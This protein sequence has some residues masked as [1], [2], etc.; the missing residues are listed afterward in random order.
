MLIPSTDHDRHESFGNVLQILLPVVVMVVV[1]EKGV[2]ARVVLVGSHEMLSLTED[3]AD[4]SIDARRLYTYL[5]LE[6]KVWMIMYYKKK[7][8]REKGHGS[9]AEI[10]R[11]KRVKEESVKDLGML[12]IVCKV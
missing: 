1:E 9:E 12:L 3:K 11:V 8:A 10:A 7:D 4:G 5:E 2:G 6:S